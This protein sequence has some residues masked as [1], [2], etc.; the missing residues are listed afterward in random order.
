VERA[1]DADAFDVEAVSDDE[2]FELAD[3]QLGGQPH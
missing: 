1:D 3:S 2:L